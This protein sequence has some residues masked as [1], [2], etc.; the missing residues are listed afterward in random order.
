MGNRNTILCSP[1]PKNVRI[2]HEKGQV[3]EFQYPILASKLMKQ[4][5]NHVVVYRYEDGKPTAIK[6]EPSPTSKADYHS[7]EIRVMRAN[8]RLELGHAYF[9]V[10]IPEQYLYRFSKF[11]NI[12]HSQVV[13]I[14]DDATLKEWPPTSTLKFSEAG[15]GAAFDSSP[16]MESKILRSPNS[17]QQFQKRNGLRELKP[18]TRSSM[19]SKTGP[20]SSRQRHSRGVYSG[21][22][23]VPVG[24]SFNRSNTSLSS[25]KNSVSHRNLQKLSGLSRY[26]QYFRSKYGRQHWKPS[27]ATIS[28]SDE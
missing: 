5:P 9:L 20:E 26:Y 28:E 19:V 16:R 8:S 21:P 17:C 14:P 22:K 23:R 24:G 18:G 10:R 1:S 13:P 7:T 4:Y 3:M 15:A 12:S 6:S 25:Q 11:F 2:Y 27:L